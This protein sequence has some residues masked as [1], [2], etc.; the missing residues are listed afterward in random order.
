MATAIDQKIDPPAN[1]GGTDVIADWLFAV[2]ILIKHIK[3]FIALIIPNSRREAR[4]E[5]HDPQRNCLR[6]VGTADLFPNANGSVNQRLAFAHI[7]NTATAFKHN[8]HEILTVGFQMKC[9]VLSY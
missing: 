8:G 2:P 5:L 7:G 3:Y 4:R 6:A 1:A 9:G